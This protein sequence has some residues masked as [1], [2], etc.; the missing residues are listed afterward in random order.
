MNGGHGKSGNYRG[1][2]A[3]FQ[4]LTL[5]WACNHMRFL[6]R[7]AGIASLR[8]NEP[9]MTEMDLICAICCL[10]D[11]LICSQLLPIPFC[12]S[13]SSFMDLDLLRQCVQGT[14]T[15]LPIKN[16]DHF[17]RGNL[18]CGQIKL[19]QTQ[20]N[21]SHQS[22]PTQSHQTTTPITGGWLYNNSAHKKKHKAAASSW[23]KYTS[24]GAW[25]WNLWDTI[26]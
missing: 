24:S 2:W 9:L 3:K 14:E 26:N 23:W 17:H 16:S 13:L 8:R 11:S 5:Y 7:R 20:L 15:H 22:N 18:K 21:H 19:Q 4:Y 10:R 6:Y 25:S 1:Q 12:S